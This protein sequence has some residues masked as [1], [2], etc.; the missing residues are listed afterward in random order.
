M[1][2]SVLTVSRVN[3]NLEGREVLK[4]QNLFPASFGIGTN[5]TNDFHRASDPT[6]KSKPLN[7]VIKLKRIDGLECVKLTDDTTKHAGEADEVSRVEKK[8]DDAGRVGA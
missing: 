6:A 2:R 4:S 5:L 3:V 1:R 8:L 7:I